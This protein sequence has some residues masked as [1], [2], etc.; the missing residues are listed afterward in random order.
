LASGSRYDILLWQT[1]LA[2]KAIIM[3]INSLTKVGMVASRLDQDFSQAW[4]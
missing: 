3:V 2:Q 4:L 1:L